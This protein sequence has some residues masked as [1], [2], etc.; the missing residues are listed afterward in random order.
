MKMYKNNIMKVLRLKP[1]YQCSSYSHNLNKY[2]IFKNI[3][4]Y[5]AVL[6]KI[7]TVI[8]IIVYVLYF[9]NL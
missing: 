8:E 4:L 5:Y 9:Y 2:W 7:D 3:P 1:C 6:I